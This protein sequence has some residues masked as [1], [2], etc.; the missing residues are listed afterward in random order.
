MTPNDSLLWRQLQAAGL[1]EG[2]CPAASAAPP[3]FTRLALGIAGWI[4]TLFLLGFL[5]VGLEFLFRNEA[6]AVVAGL[7]LCL[8]AAALFRRPEL[9]DFPAQAALALSFTGQVLLLVGLG[10][11][12]DP[13]ELGM[14]LLVALVEGTLLVLVRQHFHRL[15]C[16]AVAALALAYAG[17]EL[18]LF[19]LVPGFLSLALV[20][21]W[22]LELPQARHGALLRPLGYGL[23]VAALAVQGSLLA[24]QLLQEFGWHR[25]SPAAPA[26]PWLGLGLR[27]AA[28]L[29]LVALLL[30]RARVGWQQRPALAAFAATL[31]LLLTA[32]KAPGLLLGVTLLL[33]G[34][35]AGNRLLLGLGLAGTLGYLSHYYYAL[36]LTL[37]RKSAILTGLGLLLLAGWWLL[38]RHGDR[39]A[40]GDHA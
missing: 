7:C 6:A 13:G 12:L 24:P 8:G 16:A 35:G 39:L 31:V 30:R 22:A 33:L 37:L 38:R 29:L 36:Q 17:G 23:T 26:L 3:W 11:V 28:L 25:W 14:A 4:A 5:A 40:G 21:V 34:F 19:P 20:A 18:R 27:G 1:A 32:A 15:A 9:G 2:D 10:E